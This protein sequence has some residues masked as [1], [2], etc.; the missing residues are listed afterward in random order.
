MLKYNCANIRARPRTRMQMEARLDAA[1]RQRQ[2]QSVRNPLEPLLLKVIFTLHSTLYTRSPI[3]RA[4][5]KD[6]PILKQVCFE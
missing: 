5:Y 3:L 1:E 4:S 6:S 2:D